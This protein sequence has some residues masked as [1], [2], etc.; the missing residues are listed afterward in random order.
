MKQVE[1]MS[2]RSERLAPYNANQTERYQR[3]FDNWI[4]I[5]LRL[6]VRT[7]K[8]SGDYNDLN[9]PSKYIKCIII[10]NCRIL[11][12]KAKNVTKGV[13]SYA[14]LVRATKVFMENVANAEGKM[15]ITRITI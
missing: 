15:K 10:W 5:N 14:E 6:F 9:F 4:R 11:N 2:D 8:P 12:E 3:K 13:L 7:T 1:R